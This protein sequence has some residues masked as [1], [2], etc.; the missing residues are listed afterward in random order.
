MIHTPVFG[1]NADDHSVPQDLGIGPQPARSNPFGVRIIPPSEGIEPLVVRNV[2]LGMGNVPQTERNAAICTGVIAMSRK[3]DYIPANDVEF[4]KWLAEFSKGL[5]AHLARIGMTAEE[6]AFVADLQAEVKAAVDDLNRK[7]RECQ[8]AMGRK[9][10]LRRSVEKTI[11]PFVGRIHEVPGMTDD[12]RVAL[13][14][15]P[16][17]GKRVRR[18][19]GP[20]V[21]LLFLEPFN[22]GV[23][24]HFGE[25]P[26]NER[27][28][29][30][31]KWAKAC[32]IYRRKQGEEDFHMIACAT[33][34]PYYDEDFRED[35]VKVSY[36]AKYQGRTCRDL[37]MQSDTAHA[38]T[39]GVRHASVRPPDKTA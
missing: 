14:L 15:N 11:R 13:S 23:T 37:G 24:V 2:P 5:N 6:V 29:K 4:V 39:G 36:M 30:R 8:A 1:R 19:V 35:V 10:A 31:P 3:E 9:V 34:S 7:R 32:A 16:H 33:Q 38:V 18:E 21:P 28:N 27:R 17:S 22:G 25:H 12:L 26:G 20:E